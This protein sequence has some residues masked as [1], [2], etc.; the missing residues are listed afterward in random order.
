MTPPL[1]SSTPAQPPSTETIRMPAVLPAAL[2]AVL[3]PSAV[4]SLI[5]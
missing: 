3:A 4:G 5:V 2:S 1:T